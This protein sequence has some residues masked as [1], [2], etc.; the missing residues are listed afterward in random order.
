MR[1]AYFT[2]EVPWGRTEQFILTE[3][4]CALGRGHD[5]VIVPVRPVLSD[6]FPDG[7]DLR[8]RALPLALYC[9]HYLL[10]L[11][12]WAIRRPRALARVFGYIVKSS[13][14]GARRVVENAALLPKAA[15][16]ARLLPQLGVEHIHAHWVS[17]PGSMALFVAELSRIPF[18]LTAHRFDISK[19]SLLSEK[20]AAAM[21]VRVISE[22][23]R[24]ELLQY[25]P[26]DTDVTKIVTIH[27]GVK[28]PVL[29][30]RKKNRGSIVPL[31]VVPARFVEKKGHEY[32]LEAVALFRQ[33]A[34]F[35]ARIILAG[36]GPRWTFLKQ[37]H[38]NLK[39]GDSVEFSGQLSHE[40]LLD[41]YEGGCV[42]AVVLPSVVVADGDRE[43]I[44]VALMEAMAFGIP[45]I[46]TLTGGTPELV[47]GAGVLI[48]ERD[49][50][51]LADE[52][53]RLLT[54]DVYANY[55]AVAG[56]CRVEELFSVDSTVRQLE[57]LWGGN[58]FVREEEYR[59]RPGV[60]DE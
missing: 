20:V 28:L 31:I 12:Y 57:Q 18:S 34:G 14:G 54:D 9:F 27:M 56:R 59:V 33:R 58:T 52:L 10:S 6:T 19:R 44:P 38:E 2:L 7:A 25:L 16:L 30:A 48:P 36:D 13:S 17:S 4:R 39:L 40:R 8:S 51:A 53:Q 47:E 1:V 32:L 21:F 11:P 49:S 5:V 55:L 50:H 24:V 23:G 29:P 15:H 26:R 37:L 60:G 45:V 46:A 41:L 42:A 22:D 35:P 3:V 43:G